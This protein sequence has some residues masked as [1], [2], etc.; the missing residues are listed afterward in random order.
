MYFLW[1]RP[2]VRSNGLENKKNYRTHHPDDCTFRIATGAAPY[3]RTTYMWRRR[4][5]AC[6]HLTKAVHL[7]CDLTPDRAALST[8]WPSR[9]HADTHTART[10]HT[11]P[12]LDTHTHT[13]QEQLHCSNSSRSAAY[14]GP[15]Q[16]RDSPV[17]GVRAAYP[18]QLPASV[19]A[20]ANGNRAFGRLHRRSSNGTACLA[21]RQTRVAR[22][23]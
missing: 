20:G 21:R 17:T 16:E 13:P 11:S 12:I 19:L 10:F 2:R 3:S 5:A 18:K 22:D 7:D 14:C 9:Q 15:L 1:Y 23:S 8:A 4:G 6:I